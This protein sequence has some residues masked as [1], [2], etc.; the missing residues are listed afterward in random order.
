M[1]TLILLAATFVAFPVAYGLSWVAS[2]GWHRGKREHVSRLIR[3]CSQGK[4]H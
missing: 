3:E 2:R 1:D 4:P